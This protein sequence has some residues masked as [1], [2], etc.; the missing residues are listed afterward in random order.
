MEDLAGCLSQSVGGEGPG[1]LA[2]EL[3]AEVAEQSLADQLEQDVVV[4]F[5]GRVD[6]E[7][8]AEPDEAVLEEESCAP[9][10]FPRLLQ[11]VQRVPG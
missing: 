6:V 10:R 8:G 1:V 7:V 11:R 4:A 5:E 3:L 2:R 9:A